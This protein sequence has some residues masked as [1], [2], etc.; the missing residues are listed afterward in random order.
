VWKVADVQGQTNLDCQ[1][2]PSPLGIPVV[3]V[4]ER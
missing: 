2:A 4:V 1:F 3:P